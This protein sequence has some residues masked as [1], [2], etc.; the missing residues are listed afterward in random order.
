MALTSFQDPTGSLVI[1]IDNL[2][3]DKG[4]II[5][6]IFNNDKDFLKKDYANQT[7]KVQSD[8]TVLCVF[9]NLPKGIYSISVIHDENENGQLDKNILGIPTEAF[10]FSNNKMGM[11]GPPSFKD[12][13]VLIEEK[14]KE[15]N[16]V[17]K[18]F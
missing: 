1:A 10:G 4:V 16:I 12:C 17:L 18:N 8:S 13:G 2:K 11:F 6:A 14:K 15:I 3:T 9:D 7:L 5:V